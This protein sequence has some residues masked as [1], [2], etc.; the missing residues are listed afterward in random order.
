MI[1]G[2]HNRSLFSMV[3]DSCSS[4]LSLITQT[5]SASFSCTKIN[6]CINSISI[7]HPTIRYRKGSQHQ[8]VDA[9]TRDPTYDQPDESEPTNDVEEQDSPGQGIDETSTSESDN[10]DACQQ[11]HQICVLQGGSLS[12][13][14]EKPQ[15]NTSSLE[16][17]AA[18]ALTLLSCQPTLLEN[19]LQA[20]S[21]PDKPVRVYLDGNIGSGK[22]TILQLLAH[23]LKNT[24]WHLI[25]EP[26]E[27]WQNLLKNYYQH[28][29]SP[30]PHQPD[31]DLAG[32]LQLTVLSAYLQRVPPAM[33]TPAIIMERGPWS[34]INVFAPAQCLNETFKQVFQG[35]IEAVRPLLDNAMPT[36]V[37]YLYLEPII[38]LQRIQQRGREGER[39]LTL[40]YLQTLH[41]HYNEAIKAFN[42]PVYV[43]DAFKP[44]EQILPFV[45]NALKAIR[46]KQLGSCSDD[47]LSPFPSDAI[48]SQN[49]SKT[50]P[51]KPLAS[52]GET[53]GLPCQQQ[54]CMLN[55]GNSQ[56]PPQVVPEFH[57]TEMESP[58][59][60]EFST[61]HLL[62]DS[63]PSS[64]NVFVQQPN[65]NQFLYD[66]HVATAG[67]RPMPLPA[68]TVEI[69]ADTHSSSIYEYS[70][71]PLQ[72][73]YDAQQEIPVLFQQNAGT[74]AFSAFF[75]QLYESIYHELPDV[76]HRIN[77]IRAL[78]LYA[79]LGPW[80]AN[81]PTANIQVAVV[82]IEA[83]GAIKVIP[84]HTNGS[85]TV[86]VDTVRY[87]AISSSVS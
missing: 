85:E 53:H 3:N 1:G 57:P 7:Y 30:K 27:E 15:Q 4:R 12:E 55:P 14:E 68:T 13:T 54:L 61:L 43:V 63:G 56:S 17:E 10:W 42:G 22:T 18:E 6:S 79:Q 20:P 24:E 66:S 76:N 80:Q 59:V 9:L 5:C 44:P 62:N 38:C 46:K 16:E 81:G 70:A 31:A 35:L 72:C 83:K 37:I 50:D 84:I 8:S 21:N 32:Y 40:S 87:A 77:N 25:P 23:N 47:P 82:P 11:P 69:A 39:H 48:P 74:F 41:K 71:T 34:S 45:L 78:Q 75:N 33:A 51:Y 28:N 67:H 49:S 26:I 29:S 60:H 64:N 2:H 36:A 73:L 86:Y 58:P 19:E 65:A 52:V